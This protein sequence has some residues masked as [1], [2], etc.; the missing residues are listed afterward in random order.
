MRTHGFF[1]AIAEIPASQIRTEQAWLQ[2]KSS[3]H[4]SA[5]PR[6]CTTARGIPCSPAPPLSTDSSDTL[7]PAKLP[8]IPPG[9]ACSPLLQRTCA[10]LL[11]VPEPSSEVWTCLVTW[12]SICQHLSM[13]TASKR[14]RCCFLR[15]LQM[16]QCRQAKDKP[17]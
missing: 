8:G 10:F 11:Q 3:S 14:E 2:W 9:Q 16:P 6:P 1:R 17:I 4:T 12:A 7:N 15:P 13:Q 5:W